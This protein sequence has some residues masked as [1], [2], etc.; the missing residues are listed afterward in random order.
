MSYRFAA[1]NARS[2]VDVLA[3]VGDDAAEPNANVVPT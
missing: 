3:A 1:F 2:P